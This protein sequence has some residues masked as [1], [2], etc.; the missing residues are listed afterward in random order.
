LFYKTY[1]LSLSACSRP[2][3]LW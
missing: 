2:R 3:N 1:G